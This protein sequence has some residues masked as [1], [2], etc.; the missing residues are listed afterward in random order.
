MK[1]FEKTVKQLLSDEMLAPHESFK[2]NLKETIMKSTKP[3]RTASRWLV[4][5]AISVAVLAI[6][7]IGMQ[8]VPSSSN[9]PI[10]K[11]PFAPAVVSAATIE[12]KSKAFQTNLKNIP[13]IARVERVTAGPLYD[14]CHE[15]VMGAQAGEVWSQY[16]YST[17]DGKEAFYLL[18]QFADGTTSATSFYNPSSTQLSE[19]ISSLMGYPFSFDD[20]YYET[21]SDTG[22]PTSQKDYPAVKENGKYVYKVNLAARSRDNTCGDEVKIVRYSVDATTYAITRGAQY[23]GRVDEAHRIYAFDIDLT[24]E[25]LTESQALSR[26]TQAGFDQNTAVREFPAYIP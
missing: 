22:E 18:K 1:Q 16:A 11:N 5:P 20:G 14:E 23:K 26:M 7:A 6:A 15:G 2:R 4:V 21:V 10:V 25:Q 19:V 17:K 13:F 9:Q 12:K 3:T 24:T 8:F